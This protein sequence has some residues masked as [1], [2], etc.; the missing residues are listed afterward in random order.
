MLVLCTEQQH[1]QNAVCVCM[2]AVSGR[3]FERKKHPKQNA[4]KEEEKQEA[5]SDSGW[6]EVVLLFF[7]FLSM[8]HELQTMK[9]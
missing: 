3:N 7:F 5:D 2:N 8:K 6:S 9:N 1:A 4:S